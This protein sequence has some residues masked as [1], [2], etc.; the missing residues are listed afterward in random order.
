M[1]LHCKLLRNDAKVRKTVSIAHE[2]VFPIELHT[3]AS[4]RHISHSALLQQRQTQLLELREMTDRFF[5]GLSGIF[6]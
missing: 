4:H 3:P 6:R 5:L 2:S 1:K